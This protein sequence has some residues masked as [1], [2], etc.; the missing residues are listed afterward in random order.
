MAQA[1]QL[2]QHTSGLLPQHEVDDPGSQDLVCAAGLREHSAV[3]CPIPLFFFF[4]VLERL[5]EQQIA[6]PCLCPQ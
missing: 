3:Q 4:F 5:Q 2:V 1:S 6:N